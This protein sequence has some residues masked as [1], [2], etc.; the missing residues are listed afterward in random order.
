MN[1]RTIQF[2]KYKC[3]MNWARYGNG[4]LALQLDDAKNG[5]PVLVATVNMPDEEID[6][7]EVII[8]N[9]HENEGILNVLIH[10]KIISRPIRNVDG[11][12]GILVCK[13]LITPDVIEEGSKRMKHLSL[14]E[15]FKINEADKFTF[16]TEKPTGKWR[17]FDEDTYHIKLKGKEVGQIVEVVAGNGSPKTYKIRLMV[18]KTDKITDSNPNCSWKWITLKKE[19]ESLEAAKLWLNQ[20]IGELQKA[21]I[22]H[23][24]D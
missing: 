6:G 15:N 1:M 7:D 17:S 4:R 19:C 12:P 16:K 23:P 9:Y 2:G 10:D 5:E 20:A 8:K 13:L 21:Y 22:L 3:V 24:L 11:N 14:Y 18:T